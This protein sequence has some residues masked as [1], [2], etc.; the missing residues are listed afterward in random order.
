[1]ALVVLIV[2]AA[3]TAKWLG[4]WSL[5]LVIIA[6]LESQKNLTQ[7]RKVAK[8]TQSKQR[9]LACSLCAFVWGCSFFHR[10]RS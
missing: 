5:L 2:L 1:M 3:V 10:I 9:V 4:W 7:G 6:A 8:G